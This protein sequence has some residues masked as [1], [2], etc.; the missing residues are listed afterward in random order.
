MTNITKKEE[1]VLN[2]I[3]IFNPEYSEGIPIAILRED[4][5]INEADLIEI[6]DSLSEKNLI[7]FKDNNIKLLDSNEE[8]KITKDLAEFD[9]NSNEKEAYDLILNNV[10]EK[11]L[12]P[13]YTLE[14]KLLYGDLA[15]SN[16]RM[17]NIILSLQNKGLLKSITKDDGEY[18][19][20]IP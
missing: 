16:L 13:K 1:I 4:V 20:F 5:D 7:D 9:L 14:G 8:N 3:K 10:D 6:L 11:N 19:L 12:I 18:Y 15:L 17:Y 2:Q